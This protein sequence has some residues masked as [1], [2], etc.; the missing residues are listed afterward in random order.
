MPIYQGRSANG[1]DAIQV[2]MYISP[3]GKE[4]SNMP[5]TQE[6]REIEKTYRIHWKVWDWLRKNGRTMKE[7]Y[8]LIQ[9]RKSN[10]SKVCREYVI[11]FIGKQKEDV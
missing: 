8:E 5:F 4:W 6:Q 3:D 1:E 11:D 10:L 9:Q 2:G 7:E